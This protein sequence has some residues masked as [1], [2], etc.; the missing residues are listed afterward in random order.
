MDLPP[1]AA[2]A[3]EA[4]E[5]AEAAEAAEAA[6]R[7][8]IRR[9]ETSLVQHWVEEISSY[10]SW[11]SIVLYLAGAGLGVYFE[12]DGFA[13]PRNYIARVLAAGR[14]CT[15]LYLV[16]SVRESQRDFEPAHPGLHLPSHAVNAIV[17]V[18]VYFYVLSN[19]CSNFWLIFGKL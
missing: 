4:A 17:A 8:E 6:R 13:D 18:T 16:Y 1:E 11:A 9:E 2:A 12:L 19:F 15:Y 14:I 7:Q 5:S 10:L 3:A